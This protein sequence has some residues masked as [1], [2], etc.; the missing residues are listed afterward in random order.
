MS[1]ELKTYTLQELYARPIEPISLA[2][3]RICWHPACT[4]WAVRP[5]WAKAGWRCSSVWPSA[6]ASPFWGSRPSGTRG[7]LHLALEDG[8]RRLHI[9]ALR[10][11]EEAPAGLHLCSHAH[12]IGQGLEQQLDQMLAE[13]P[14]IKLVIIDTLQ[15]VR[16]G[17]RCQP[18]LRQRLPGCL[19]H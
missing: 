6:V 10:L 11:T 18:L 13:H 8:P 15:K 16:D 14:A 1:N 17:S 4:S 7:T 19:P 9:R 5:K 2:G 3:G 12:L